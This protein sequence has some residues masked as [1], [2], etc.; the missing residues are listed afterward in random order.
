MYLVIFCN[1]IN[2][3]CYHLRCLTSQAYVEGSYHWASSSARSNFSGKKKTSCHDI[4][5]ERWN[6]SSLDDVFFYLTKHTISQRNSVF[7][8]EISLKRIF[9]PHLRTHSILIVCGSRKGDNE[10][11]FFFFSLL[12]STTW[13]WVPAAVSA[14]EAEIPK[15]VRRNVEKKCWK[16]SSLKFA[17][18]KKAANHSSY[19]LVQKQQRQHTSSHYGSTQTCQANSKKQGA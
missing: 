18:Q 4:G 11:R 14:L 10:L 2:T 7:K 19:I 12:N 3:A 9:V 15:V 5:K 16:G 6:S 17:T 1:H 8:K 13:K